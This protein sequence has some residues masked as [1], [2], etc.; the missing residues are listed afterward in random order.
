MLKLFHFCS[1]MQVH[2]D[3]RVV[4]TNETKLNA[5]PELKS[6]KIKCVNWLNLPQTKNAP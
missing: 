6:V 2:L 5:L 4:E 1:L 3:C